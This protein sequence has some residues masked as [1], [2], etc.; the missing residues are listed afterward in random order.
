MILAVP[1][2]RR[3]KEAASIFA[4][5]AC[6]AMSYSM[7]HAQTDQTITIQMLDSKT[8]RPITTSEFQV[9]ANH[10]TSRDHI[11]WVRPSKDGVGEL[12]IT[13]DTDVIRVLAQYGPS[14]W[15]YVNCDG[16][17]DRGAKAIDHWYAVPEILNS[18]VVAPN[19][20][21]T[22]K[23]IAKPGE[24]IFFVRPMNFWEKFRE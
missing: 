13:H 11:R 3:I 15:S 10:D 14:R 20:C 18:G 16:A 1:P 2:L 23:A 7:L 12:V 17:N 9:W 5:V 6:I 4:L 21:S 24:F 19:H 8:G 22:A